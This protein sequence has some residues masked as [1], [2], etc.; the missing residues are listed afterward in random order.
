M[1]NVNFNF[2]IHHLQITAVAQTTI[3]LREHQGSAIR[4]ALFHA[5]RGPNR[6]TKDGYTGFCT[7]KTAP[8]CWQCPLHHVCPVS[9]LV[10]TLDDQPNPQ[11]AHGREAPRPYIIRP[12]LNPQ[13]TYHPGDPFNFTLGICADAL[14]L[15]PYLTI[16][17]QRLQHEGIGQRLP[18]NNHQRGRLQIQTITA[19]HPLTQQQQPI[20][21][22]GQ[23]N[24]HIMH[25]QVNFLNFS[26]CHAERSEASR[27]RL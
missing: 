1:D 9:Q 21:T 11:T 20:H 26:A 25:R 24:I 22:H 15:F 4:G 6:P 17:L 14:K 10:A 3:Q 8:N 16:A 12:P 5:L 2:T 13:T 18:Q 27:T 19:I 7:N 23:T